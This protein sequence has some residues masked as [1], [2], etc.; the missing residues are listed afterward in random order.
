MQLQKGLPV[1]RF[2]GKARVGGLRSEGSKARESSLA[3]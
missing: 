3:R 1:S 2:I